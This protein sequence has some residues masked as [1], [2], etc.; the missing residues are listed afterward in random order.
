MH[1]L[2]SNVLPI[3]NDQHP[4]PRNLEKVLSKFD[5]NKKEL[6]EDHVNKF[7]LVL[8]LLNVEH[9]HVACELFPY[10]FKGIASACY[11]LVTPRS[12]HNWKEFQT[13][14]LGK[15]RDDKSPPK[16][17]LELSRIKKS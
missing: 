1:W 3:P 9:E 16:L 8:I 6:I 5:P 10:T 2:A 4:L 17:V 11:F 14:F 12:I 15:F 7:M 13:T